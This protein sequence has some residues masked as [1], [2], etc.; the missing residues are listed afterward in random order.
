MMEKNKITLISIAALIAVTPLTVGTIQPNEVRAADILIRK[1]IC[2]L[3]LAM[4]QTVG[5]RA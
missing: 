4:I 3:Q 5:T 1:T 2:I